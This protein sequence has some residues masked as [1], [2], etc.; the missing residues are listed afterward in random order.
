MGAV[1]RARQRDLD[2]VVALKILR[3][4]LDSDPGFA[5]RFAKEARALAQLNHPGIVTLYEYGRSSAGRYF[6][7]MEFVDGVNLRGLLAAGRLSAREALAIVPPLCDA[8]QYAHDRGVV[9]CDIKPENILVDRLGRVKIADFGIARLASAEGQGSAA[10]HP[11]GITL[12]ATGLAAGTPAYMAPEQR[13]HPAAV[14]HRADLYALGVVLYQMLT[15]ELPSPGQLEP[16][17]RRVQVDVRLD[18][19]VLRALATDPARR[20]A[21]ATEMKTALETVPASAPR[22]S[23][24]AAVSPALPMAAF[25]VLVCVFCN[26]LVATA[27]HLPARVA[28]RFDAAGRAN[29]WMDRANHLLFMELFGLGLPLFIAALFYLIRFL[30][31]H[32]FNLPHRDHWLAPER[33][34]ATYAFIFVRGLWLS[35]LTL[36]F[37]TG[38][39]LLLTLANQV[40]PPHLPASD[41]WLLVGGYTGAVGIWAW[42]FYQAFRRRSR[43]LPVVFSNGIGGCRLARFHLI[44]VLLA[45][46]FATMRITAEGAAPS[47]DRAKASAVSKPEPPDKETSTSTVSESSRQSFA[48]LLEA[49]PDTFADLASA[50][51]K[52]VARHFP[53]TRIEE[54]KDTLQISSSTSGSET[55]RVSLGRIRTLPATLAPEVKREADFVE[56]ANVG[57]DREQGEG[58]RVHLVLG[59]K[60]PDA[61]R[62]ELMTLLGFLH[63]PVRTMTTSAGESLRLYTQSFLDGADV[64]SVERK[65]AADTHADLG[66]AATSFTLRLSSS[67][68]FR[69]NQL[70]QIAQGRRIAF[71]YG[72]RVLSAPRVDGEISS[73]EVEISG[74]FARDEIETWFSALSGSNGV[75]QE[76]VTEL[77]WAW[78][79]EVDQGGYTRTWREAAAVFRAAISEADWK[80]SLAAARAPFGAF[81]SRRLVAAQRTDTLPGTPVGP[82]FVFQF[83]TRF[84]AKAVAI[85]TLTFTR[86]A[87][88]GWRMSGYFIR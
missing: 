1:Y 32:G 38:V 66:A 13:A 68:A 36:G 23:A 56:F 43:Q 47:P 82:H 55:L 33:R 69:L 67:G 19:I 63:V 12:T 49:G 45:P 21:A 29:G 22:R 50:V 64:V 75:E 8:L 34:G 42:R 24:R 54:S 52:L 39:N 78:L 62:R 80:K 59:N 48:V 27:A 6:I 40:S 85:E 41:I 25:A 26:V 57:Y 46:T 79:R 83:E 3:P 17:S 4:G 15:G 61:F 77:A 76:Q 14:D 9:H 74:A 5:G 20:Y 88:G 51:K 73:E 37:T 18:E 81:E 65:Q 7:L 87:D 35:C 11:A 30:P 84:A 72:D 60:L 70:S 86:E 53:D 31:A 16:P 71:T 28:T 10:G 44:V 2:R 58:V